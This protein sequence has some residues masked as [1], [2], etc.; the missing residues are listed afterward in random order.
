MSSDNIAFQLYN[1]DVAFDVSLE[2]AKTR[3]L[4]K[5]YGSS[6]NDY[7]RQQIKN[8]LN[9]MINYQLDFITN[10]NNPIYTFTGDVD[11][12]HLLRCR[13]ERIEKIKNTTDHISLYEMLTSHELL[14]LN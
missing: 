12:E 2:M 7:L 5:L 3:V 10:F 14:L 8:K 6:L 11:V 13:R 1:R 4:N 9:S